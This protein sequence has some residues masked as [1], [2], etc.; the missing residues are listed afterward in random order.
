MHLS[1]LSKQIEASW[2][3]C[4]PIGGGEASPLVEKW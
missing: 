1:P 4:V 2:V 3:V